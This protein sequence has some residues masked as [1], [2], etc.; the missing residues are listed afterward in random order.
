MKKKNVSSW[1]L[2]VLGQE[3]RKRDPFRVG[4][5]DSHAARSSPAASLGSAS[6]ALA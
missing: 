4:E 3:N 6:R 5:S 1:N 2:R